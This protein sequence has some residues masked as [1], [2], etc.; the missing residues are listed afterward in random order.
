MTGPARRLPSF[1]D[2]YAE[3]ERL[4]EGMTGEILEPGTLRTMARPGRAHRRSAQ[5]CFRS[6]EGAD[7]ASGGTGWWIEQEAEILLP[8]ERLAVPDL[9]GWRVERVPELPDENPI[10]VLPDWCCEVLSPTTA[11]EDRALKLPLYARSGVSWIWVVDPVLRL[12]EVFESVGGKPL[13]VAT[14][15]ED[16]TGP[17][18]PFTVD[19][20]L[21][22]WWIARGGPAMP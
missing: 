2:L 5:Q 14:A 7:M 16:D 20:A 8:G 12:V 18:A 17:L 19:I 13:L 4:P 15:K 1:N 6:L 11:R 10:A 21:T 22:R 3:I 9:S